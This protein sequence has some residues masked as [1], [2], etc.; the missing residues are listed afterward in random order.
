[1]TLAAIDT[2]WSSIRVALIMILGVI[3]FYL[4]N[5][6]LRSGDD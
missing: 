2:S 3:W 4:L 5:E 6:Q 1:M